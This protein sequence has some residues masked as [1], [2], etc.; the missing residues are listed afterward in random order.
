MPTPFDCMIVYDQSYAQSIQGDEKIDAP[1]SNTQ[2]GVRYNRAYAYMLDAFHQVGLSAAFAWS[3]AIR[4]AG[5]VHGYWTHTAGGWQQHVDDATT[6][7]VFN[8]FSTADSEGQVQYQKLTNDGR[9]RMFKSPEL[10]HL[11]RDKLAT[12][13]RF[14]QYSIPTVAVKQLTPTSLCAARQQ[15]ELMMPRRT[16]HTELFVLKNRFGIGGAQTHLLDMRDPTWERMLTEEV[17]HAHHYILQPFIECDAG[18][19]FGTHSGRIDLRV[20]LL[21]GQPIE[22]YIRIAKKGEFRANASQGGAVAYISLA[23]I[24]QEVIHVVRSISTELTADAVL[25]ALDFL[26]SNT[27][28]IYLIEGNDSP[29]LIWF[30]Q[31]DEVR[32]KKVIDLIVKDI[33]NRII[34]DAFYAN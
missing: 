29:G 12:H 27:G 10:I 24:P 26:R 31:T 4:S 7:F 23:E 5:Q 28:E 15:L 33:R 16:P 22:S 11:L 19:Q 2:D 21:R 34:T 1:F 13:Q 14:P 17:D 18:F 8:R 32:T 3:G 9:V 30:N 25:Y 6:S 20:V